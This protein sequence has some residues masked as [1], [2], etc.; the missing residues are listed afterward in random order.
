MRGDGSTATATITSCTFE[1]GAGS[2]TDSVDNN[3]GGKITFACPAGSTGTPV[4]IT[5]PDEELDASQLPPAK[6]LV[7][8]TPKKP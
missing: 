5:K 7:H 4:V 2:N 8:C 1:G 3:G 6:Q